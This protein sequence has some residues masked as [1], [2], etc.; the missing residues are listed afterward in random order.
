MESAPQYHGINI[1]AKFDRINILWEKH[2]LSGVV[3]HKFP[4]SSKSIFL[5]YC[6]YLYVYI[7]VMFRIKEN[8]SV[9]DDKFLFDF[10]STFFSSN[11]S[12][13]FS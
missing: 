6:L 3:N 7:N 5:N 1:A 11:N 9:T 2:R 12:M 4:H 10:V 13:F 8:N